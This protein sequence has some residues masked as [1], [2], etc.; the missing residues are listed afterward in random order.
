MMMNAQVIQLL[1]PDTRAKLENC[2]KTKIVYVK[3]ISLEKLTR[4]QAMGFT[5][6][7]K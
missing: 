3:S 1:S 2:C 7:I 5:V 6:I 4:L